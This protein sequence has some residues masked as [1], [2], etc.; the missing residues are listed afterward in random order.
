MTAKRTPAL[1]RGY[2]INSDGHLTV[3]NTD[4]LLLA[5]E[6]G[7]PLICMDEDIIRANCRSHKN[8]LQS[9]FGPEALPCFASKAF[10]CKTMYRI[11]A[12]EGFGVDLVSPGEAATALA[13][14]FPMEKTFFHG[15]NKSDEDLNY[16]LKVGIGTIVVDGDDELEALEALCEKQ[17]RKQNILL[18]ITPGIDPHTHK[19]IITGNIDSKFGNAIATGQAMSIV[20][21]ALNCP[22][23]ALSG[24]HCHIGSQIFEVDPFDD[25]LSIMAAF[26]ASVKTETGVSLTTLNL[27]G[28]F[29]VPYVPEETAFDLSAHFSALASRLS[30]V[31]KDAGIP[32]P[33]IV[34]EPGRSIV[35]DAGTTLYTVGSVKEIPGF[36]NYVSIDGGMTDNPRY[37]LY[38]SRYTVYNAGK[39][40]TPADYPCTLAG[41]CCESG[42]LIGEGLYLA[43][44]SR[45]DIVAVAVTG[46]Y[47]YAMASHYN[48]VPKPAVVF[49]AGGK[50]RVAIERETFEDLYRFDR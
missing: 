14:G 27:G 6:Y 9:A 3:G 39:M 37:T 25:A 38:G 43:K 17:N 34:T 20:R 13:A 30:D 23:I 42:D 31:C 47:T 44:P 29:G 1:L 49:L 16:A 2:G 40:H 50:S 4:A 48:R 19:K 26:L 21:K 45:G 12:E 33:R 28:G 5:K 18:R 8:A 46:A 22:H 15:N 41:R 35:A 36:R 24:L 10:S 32:V 7:T 11:V